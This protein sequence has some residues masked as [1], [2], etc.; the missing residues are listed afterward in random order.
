MSEYHDPA[1]GGIHLPNTMLEEYDQ[2]AAK[3]IGYAGLFRHSLKQLDTR[4]DLVW[5]KPGAEA[6]DGG[7]WYIVR[8]NDDA[9][10]S[11]WKIQTEQGEYADPG[12]EHLEWL[13]SIDSHRHPGVYHDH[14]KRQDER[15]RQGKK[16]MEELHREF[17]EKLEERVAQ[18]YG[19]SIAVTGEMKARAAGD[20]VTE[21]GVVLPSPDAITAA[22]SSSRIDNAP[23]VL[24]DPADDFRPTA[25]DED[26]A[27][28]EKA[29]A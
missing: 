3:S 9:P 5:A 17:R 19:T 24:A 28:P 21:G 15:V 13:K 29:S 2:Q 8:R 26:V 14:R 10:A 22:L 25:S 4:L 11:Y 18:L 6:L 27:A 7:F 1:A 23:P 16:R 12:P 20:A